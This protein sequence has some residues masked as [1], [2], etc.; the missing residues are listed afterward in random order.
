MKMDIGSAGRWLIVIGLGL[1]GLGALL[2]LLQRSGIPIGR[3]PGDF[4]FSS[5]N[6]TCFVPLASS[7]LISLVLTLL[8]NLIA[9][10]LTR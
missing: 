3:L 10:W 1:A 2:W 6:A 7:I 8:L 9:R 4:R 5:G